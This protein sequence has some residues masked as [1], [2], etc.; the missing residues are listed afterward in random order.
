MCVR[1][2]EEE[3]ERER[4]RVRKRESEKEV[5]RV[6]CILQA[7]SKH[8]CGR[9]QVFLIQ[10]VSQSACLIIILIISSNN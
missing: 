5:E 8:F 2:S 1:E 9:A 3:R 10:S 7:C 4:E 6:A